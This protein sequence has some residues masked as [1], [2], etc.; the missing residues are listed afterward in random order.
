MVE[1]AVLPQD[2]P[3]PAQRLM[4]MTGHATYAR[5]SPWCQYSCADVHAFRYL[6]PWTPLLV[7]RARTRDVHVCPCRVRLGL[8]YAVQSALSRGL[9]QTWRL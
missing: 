5:L 1:T 9:S 2:A 6:G 3:R 7:A 4:M 8:V